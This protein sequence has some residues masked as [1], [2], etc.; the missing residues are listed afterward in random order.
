MK[1]K[2]KH[3]NGKDILVTY[4]G[5][6]SNSRSARVMYLKGHQNARLGAVGTIESPRQARGV[7]IDS[8]IPNVRQFSFTFRGKPRQLLV[9]INNLIESTSSRTIRLMEPNSKGAWESLSGDVV[10]IDENENPIL[11]NPSGLAQWGDL[12]YLIDYDTMQIVILGADE[13]KGIS[14]AYAPLKTPYDLTDLFWNDPGKGQ[15][16]IILNDKLYALYMI[17][18]EGEPSWSSILFRF[19]I[20][21]NGSLVYEISATMGSNAQ[22]IIPV[23]DGKE[24]WLLIPAIGGSQKSDGTTNGYASNICCMP[25]LGD[26]IP[27]IEGP[28][29]WLTGDDI[30]SPLTA[31]DIRA[32]AAGTRGKSSVLYILTQVYVPGS[33]GNKNAL[34]RIY[35]T[36]VGQF[37]DLGDGYNPPS[38]PLSLTQALNANVL[39]VTDEGTVTNLVEDGVYVWDLLYEQTL[40]AGD[41]GD[42]LWRALGASLLAT[43][44]AK[45]EYGSPTSAGQNAYAMFGS[46]GGSNINSVDLTIE[47]VLRAKRGFSLRRSMLGSKLPQ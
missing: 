28:Q 38:P 42:R 21:S 19:T 1:L 25:A 11:F 44:A 15:A 40:E 23:Y 39:S 18:I 35:E 12:I 2:K 47:A 37:L 30:E 13:L 24:M 29:S 43:C 34:W 20:D 26:W 33:N 41:A 9:K 16:I 7:I 45:G 10:L 32:V 27:I 31:Y 3:C 22:S 4:T 6:N 46:N 14:G 36:T 8:D 5:E 17:T